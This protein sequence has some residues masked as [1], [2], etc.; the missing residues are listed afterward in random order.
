MDFI[1]KKD[2]KKLKNTQKINKIFFSNCKIC[3]PNFIAN[4]F[5]RQMKIRNTL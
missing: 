5:N 3:I 2:G 4:F 1:T